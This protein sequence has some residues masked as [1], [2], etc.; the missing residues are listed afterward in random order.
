MPCQRMPRTIFPGKVGIKN[1]KRT[2]FWARC[3]GNS[4]KFTELLF[5]RN[6][7][8]YRL[9]GLSGNNIRH[10]KLLNYIKITPGP[11]GKGLNCYT[12]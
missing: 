3:N 9:L 2:I 8:L 4:L 10:I 11:I 7:T 5:S 12:N 6:L 1:C